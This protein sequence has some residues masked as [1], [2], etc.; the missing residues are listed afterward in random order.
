MSVI[1]KILISNA[2]GLVFYI[3][4]RPSMNITK[5]DTEEKENPQRSRNYWETIFNP[6]EDNIFGRWE[7][8]DQDIKTITGKKK[9]WVQIDNSVNVFL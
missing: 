8:S 3:F 4:K 2:L 9:V 5:K 1:Q 7:I 6:G